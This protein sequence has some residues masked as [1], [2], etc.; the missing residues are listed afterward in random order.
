[1]TS[2]ICTNCTHFFAAS[3]APRCQRDATFHTDM[4]TGQRYS[5]ENRNPYNERHSIFPWHCGAQGRFFQP[6]DQT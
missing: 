6:K 4:V 5:L 3:F 1:M 2:P